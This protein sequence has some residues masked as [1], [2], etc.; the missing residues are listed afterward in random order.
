MNSLNCAGS[1]SS[2]FRAP[3]RNV[4]SQAKP[5]MPLKKNGATKAG[6]HKHT[7][8]MVKTYLAIVQADIEATHR[9]ASPVD[10]WA[11]L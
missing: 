4:A 9:Y 1:T 7:L 8:D 3:S 11:L 5:E 10:N 6:Y 2:V